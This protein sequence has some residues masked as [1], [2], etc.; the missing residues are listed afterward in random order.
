[1]A[2]S[3]LADWGMRVFGRSIL[4]DIPLDC[5]YMCNIPMSGCMDIRFRYKGWIP[6]QLQE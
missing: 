1:M 2:S 3:V 4:L 5:L 6:W